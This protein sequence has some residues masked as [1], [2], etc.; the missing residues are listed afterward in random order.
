MKTPRVTLEQWRALQ[1]VVDEGGFAQAAAAMHRSQSSVSYAVQRL[2]DQLGIPLLVLRG[3][4]AELTEAGRTLVERSRGLLRAAGDLE[5]LAHH[6]DEGWEAE[7]RLV[8]DAAFPSALLMRCLRDFL[9]LSR[10]TRVQLIEEVLSGAEDALEAGEADLAIA[11]RVPA[12]WLGEPLLAVEFMAVTHP[13][14]PLQ[15]LERPLTAGDL[16][17]E[18]QVVVRDSGISHKQDVG[19]LNAG[20]RWTVTSLDSALEAVRNGLGFAWLPAHQ[21]RP[22]IDA[23]G[24]AP[25]NLREGQRYLA[26]LY[27]VYGEPDRVGPATRELARLLT[28][29]VVAGS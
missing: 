18:L 1:A 29:A 14:H 8:V 2:Q 16:E 7:I 9:P 19:W 26:D 6:L 21:V 13:E 4:R 10:G 28:E 17:D 23:G 12:G 5:A 27:L 3:R 15:G 25:L 22:L 20:H 11:A 24:L